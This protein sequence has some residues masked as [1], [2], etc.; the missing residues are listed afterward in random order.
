MKLRISKAR[1]FIE[2]FFLIGIFIFFITLVVGQAGRKVKPGAEIL[3]NTEGQVSCTKSLPD[4]GSCSCVSSYDEDTLQDWLLY[5]KQL[6]LERL[7]EEPSNSVVDVDI[8]IQDGYENSYRLEL[9]IDDNGDVWLSNAGSYNN[10]YGSWWPYCCCN[11]QTIC[12]AMKWLFPWMNFNCSYTFW[13]CMIRGHC[14]LNYPYFNWFFW[15]LCAYF[16]CC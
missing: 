14:S 12:Y 11:H 5:Q 2:S 3:L 9:K 16:G 10:C 13:R 1:R 7:S 8:D 4:Y 6:P 15:L